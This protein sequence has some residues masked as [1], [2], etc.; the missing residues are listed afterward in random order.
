MIV[1]T[2]SSPLFF[3]FFLQLRRLRSRERLINWTIVV[4]LLNQSLGI[5]ILLSGLQRDL[6]WPAGLSLGGS[7]FLSRGTRLRDVLGTIYGWL[8]G[9]WELHCIFDG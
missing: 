8:V 3:F 2:P 6:N 1:T 5:G 7:G 4:E 9:C